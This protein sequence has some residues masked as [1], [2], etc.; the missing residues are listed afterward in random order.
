M[1]GMKI[2]A[3]VLLLFAGSAMADGPPATQPT[4]QPAIDAVADQILRESCEY[5]QKTPAF[6]VHAEVWKDEVL[7]SG[8]KIQVT[9][10]VTLD[11]SKPG[12]FHFD[13]RAHNKGRS[14]WLRR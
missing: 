1:F 6:S 7:P 11:C 3:L 9:R 2:G 12:R 5:L 13:A 8:H 4:S 10:I 14:I